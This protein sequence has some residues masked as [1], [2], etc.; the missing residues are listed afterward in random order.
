MDFKLFSSELS[1]SVIIAYGTLVI[2]Y[3]TYT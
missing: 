1:I 3:K 2:K